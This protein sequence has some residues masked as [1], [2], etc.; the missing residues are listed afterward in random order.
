MT[1][2]TLRVFDP[3]SGQPLTPPMNHN[4]DIE[5]VAFSPDGRWIATGCEDMQAR[6]F[7]AATGELSGPA[8]AHGG[9]VDAVAFNHDGTLLAT[10]SNDARLHLWEVPGGQS[11]GH[12]ITTPS[13][14]R[15]IFFSPDSL[16]LTG[17][18]GDAAKSIFRTAS[19][20]IESPPRLTMTDYLTAISGFRMNP[21][22]DIEPVPAGELQELWKSLRPP[23]QK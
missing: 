13:A 19:L 11:A 8:M 16:R 6:L 10:A 17:W 23:A 1:R 18:Y 12:R 3:A 9:F 2:R 21:A 15:R 20:A 22:G 14:A 7:A 5:A 4:D